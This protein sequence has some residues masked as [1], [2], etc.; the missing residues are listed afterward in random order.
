MSGVIRTSVRSRL[1]WRMISC[2]AAT[3]IRWV[4]PSSATVSPSWTRSATASARDVISA[5]VRIVNDGAEG[6]RYQV[7]LLAMLTRVAIVGGGPAGLMLG[8]LLELRGIDSVVI[9][10]H[11][12]EY[13]QQRVRA[14]VLEQATMD[15]MDEVGLGARMHA[16]GLVHHGVELR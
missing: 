9:E 3:G 6:E 7:M 4:K 8:R 14:G 13:V 5:G 1:R 16:E 10:R 15:L 12:R 2:P 11:D